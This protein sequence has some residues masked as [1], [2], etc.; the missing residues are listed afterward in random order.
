MPLIITTK[1]N[2]I[3]SNYLAFSLTTCKAFEPDHVT[4][5]SAASCSDNRCPSRNGHI[6]KPGPERLSPSGYVAPYSVEA[7]LLRN[8]CKDFEW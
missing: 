4:K 5:S 6:C 8:G 7:N 1:K 2:G 3:C